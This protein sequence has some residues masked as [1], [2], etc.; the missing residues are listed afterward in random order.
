[1]EEGTHRRQIVANFQFPQQTP[2]FGN[3]GHPEE[4]PLPFPYP[5]E[6]PKI[7]RQNRCKPAAIGVLGSD[8]PLPDPKNSVLSNR[9]PPKPAKVRHFRLMDINPN[10]R[11]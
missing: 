7:L 5:H 1:M 6:N 8:K 11:S 4:I 2:N 9:S 3:K 10:D